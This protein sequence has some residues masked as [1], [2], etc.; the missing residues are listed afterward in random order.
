M[1]LIAWAM[2]HGDTPWARSTLSPKKPNRTF[3]RWIWSP[4]LGGRNLSQFRGCEAACPRWTNGQS[5]PA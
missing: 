5:H 2:A 3:R 1:R 4:A